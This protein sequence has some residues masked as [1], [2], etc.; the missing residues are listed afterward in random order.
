MVCAEF[1]FCVFYI[2]LSQEQFKNEANKSQLYIYPTSLLLK[3]M[4]LHFF[5]YNIRILHILCLVFSLISFLLLLAKFWGFHMHFSNLI[6][7]FQKHL[8]FLFFPMLEGFPDE[9]L[10]VLKNNIFIKSV[11]EFHFQFYFAFISFYFLQL[12]YFYICFL[13]I[14]LHSQHANM[15]FCF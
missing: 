2:F 7:I 6:C 5:Y 14:R 8:T 10:R 12:Y 15:L 3:F 11:F 1:Y 13:G 4:R 9:D